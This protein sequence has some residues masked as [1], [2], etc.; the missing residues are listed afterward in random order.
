MGGANDCVGGASVATA[1]STANVNVL[2][3]LAHLWMCVRFTDCLYR[4]RD[5]FLFVVQA[6]TEKAQQDKPKKARTYN[7]F[8]AP[9]DIFQS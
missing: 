1:A 3:I 6:L 9:S 5:A 8:M 7:H 4:V 2:L